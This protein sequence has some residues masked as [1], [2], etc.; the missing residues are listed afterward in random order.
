MIPPPSRQFIALPSLVPSEADA[1]G[2]LC[3]RVL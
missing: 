3:R 2:L 1:G